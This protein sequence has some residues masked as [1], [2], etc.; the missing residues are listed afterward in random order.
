MSRI[1]ILPPAREAVQVTASTLE[2]VRARLTPINRAGDQTNVAGQPI[3]VG[4]WAVEEV[5][6]DGEVMFMVYP[7]EL[8][9]VVTP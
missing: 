7:A 5:T 4:D 1:R 6:E 2:H 3:A 8:I 9:E